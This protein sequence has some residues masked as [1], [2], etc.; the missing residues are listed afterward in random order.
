MSVVHYQVEA[1]GLEG[2]KVTG[3]V[4]T[5]SS[6]L[7]LLASQGGGS[8]EAQGH[9]LELTATC[10]RT[11]KTL[12]VRPITPWEWQVEGAAGGIKFSYYVKLPPPQDFSAYLQG[13]RG[14]SGAFFLGRT[15]F[16]AV[17]D[18]E[19]GYRLHFREKTY[20]SCPEEKGGF[21]CGS[22]RQLF[23]GAFGQGLY[24]LLE[25]RHGEIRLVVLREETAPADWE[26]LLTRLPAMLIQLLKLFGRA[27]FDRLTFFLFASKSHDHEGM[28]SGLA[29]PGGILLTY[30]RQSHPADEPR[31]LWL[32]LHE[33]LHQWLGLDLKAGEPG[34]E[35]FFEGFTGFFTLLLLKEGGLADLAYVKSVVA[36]NRAAY[37]AAARELLGPSPGAST[38]R[39]EFD[40][41]FHG[42]FF[43]AWRWDQDLRQV[44]PRGLATWMRKFYEKYRGES[45]EAASLLAALKATA[46]GGCLPGYFPDFLYRQRVLSI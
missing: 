15:L 5:P 6:A 16:L 19:A 43:L 2:Y 44:Y 4:L 18:Q 24:H 1:D 17:A 3:E 27:P 14:D 22:R 26:G 12:P 28:G 33:C 40:Y 20:S 36:H 8:E 37:L 42:G 11:G 7:H 25:L 34:L 46:P 13:W 45:F 35:W 38:S 10:V 21:F 41:L 39:K 23:L 32:V 9:F 31:H 30:P 29:L